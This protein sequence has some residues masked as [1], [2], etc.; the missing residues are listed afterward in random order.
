MKYRNLFYDRGLGAVLAK[1]GHGCVVVNR[2]GFR[3]RGLRG[4]VAV[5]EQKERLHLRNVVAKSCEPRQGRRGY[6][7]K[8]PFAVSRR[9]ADLQ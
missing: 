4:P 5:L 1:A 3:A 8:E 9:F 7:T 6:A 2:A